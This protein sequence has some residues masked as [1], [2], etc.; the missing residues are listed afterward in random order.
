M[1]KFVVASQISIL[2][3]S[4]ITIEYHS[5]PVVPVILPYVVSLKFQRPIFQL[6]WD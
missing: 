3:E 5:H 2:H 4:N 6:F 1:G